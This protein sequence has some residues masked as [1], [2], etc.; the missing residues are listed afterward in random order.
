MVTVPMRQQI[1][2]L[3]DTFNAE[4]SERRS[5][6]GRLLDVDYDQLDLS[7]A[8][9]CL[10]RLQQAVDSLAAENTV[11]LQSLG[12]LFGDLIATR[13]ELDW[14][15]VQDNY[16]TDPALRCRATSQLL[17]PLTMLSKRVEQGESVRVARLFEMMT[18]DVKRFKNRP[19][20]KFW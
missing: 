13:C 1:R 3:D 16:G 5:I 2:D 12:I 11:E 19:W 20:W 10:S 9:S 17:F 8:D 4:L 14:V 6:V 15:V 18:A 7:D